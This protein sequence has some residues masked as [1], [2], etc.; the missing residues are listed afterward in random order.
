MS[1]GSPCQLVLTNIISPPPTRCKNH[2]VLIFPSTEKSPGQHSCVFISYAADAR[3]DMTAGCCSAA[4]QQDQSQTQ[5]R[6]QTHETPCFS[7]P[8]EE[9]A[10]LLFCILYI[11]IIYKEHFVNV[12]QQQCMLVRIYHLGTLQCHIYCTAAFYFLFKSWFVTN[13]QR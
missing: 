7:L 10:L 2:L 8:F 1:V 11:R 4:T 5:L 12:P 9:C 6:L 3:C 13:I